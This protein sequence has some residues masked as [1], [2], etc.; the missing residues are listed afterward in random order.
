[1]KFNKLQLFLMGILAM[2]MVMA[3]GEDTNFAE[4]IYI[5]TLRFFSATL[6]PLIT[7]LFLIFSVLIILAI[8]FLLK[9]VFYMLSQMG[10]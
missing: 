9:K 5:G 2:P 4:A 3:S 1:M 7:L 8:G 10:K 6:N